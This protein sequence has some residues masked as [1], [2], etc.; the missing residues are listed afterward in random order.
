MPQNSYKK[1]GILDATLTTSTQRTVYTGYSL[2]YAICKMHGFERCPHCPDLNITEPHRKLK[3]TECE[4]DF[5]L[6][7]PSKIC[8]TFLLEGWSTVPS[9]TVKDFARQNLRRSEVILQAEGGTIPYSIPDINT[10]HYSIIPLRKTLLINSIGCKYFQK[11]QLN[12]K[13]N[14]AEHGFLH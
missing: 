9:D 11:R 4:A 5:Y 8:L 1:A 7:H 10:V 3:G 14:E 13:Q 2:Q 12:F 6:L